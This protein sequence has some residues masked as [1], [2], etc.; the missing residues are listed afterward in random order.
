MKFEMAFLLGLDFQLYGQKDVEA[1]QYML[2]E[3]EMLV[4][5]GPVPVF[6][7]P[8]I[9]LKGGYETQPMGIALSAN[10]TYQYGAEFSV[11]HNSEWKNAKHTF[12]QT[13]YSKT[14]GLTYSI[15]S[16]SGDKVYLTNKGTGT[17]TLCPVEKVFTLKA[18]PDIGVFLYWM[19]KMSLQPQIHVKCHE[20]HES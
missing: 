16:A 10:Y 3:R 6:Y 5:V 15:G 2:Y 12:K 7:H 9:E 20:A 18:W 13:D 4:Y 1:L 17:G 19:F 8:Y 14:N 11:E